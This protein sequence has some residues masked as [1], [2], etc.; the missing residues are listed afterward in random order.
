MV[1]EEEEEAAALQEG[2]AEE[3]RLQDPDQRVALGGQIKEEIRE[4][5]LRRVEGIQTPHLLT[6]ASVVPVQAIR[7]REVMVLS[8][9]SRLDPPATVLV[10]PSASHQDSRSLG[11]RSEED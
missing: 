7:E 2:A 10:T 9:R 4:L 11:E 8:R 3:E 5:V 6:V 1:H